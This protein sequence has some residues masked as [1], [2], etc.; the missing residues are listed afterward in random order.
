M[1]NNWTTTILLLL[2]NIRIQ[3]I[4]SIIEQQQNIVKL[5]NHTLYSE[6][7]LVWK[8]AGIGDVKI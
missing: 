6:E 8:N 7:L 1:I 2:N 3:I 5:A 4:L